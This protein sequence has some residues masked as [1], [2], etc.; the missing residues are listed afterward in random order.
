MKNK[1]FILTSLK[2]INSKKKS[3]LC[4][5]NY[6]FHSFIIKVENVINEEDRIEKIE[7]RLEG[8][9]SD[10]DNS[11][12]LLRYEKLE[13]SKK[14]EKLGVY[15]LDLDLLE[16]NF[17]IDDKNKNKFISVIP[18][19]LKCREFTENEN[20]FN[21]DISKKA[22]TVSKYI[23]GKLENIST[24]V[25][26]EKNFEESYSEI[27]NTYISSIDNS[28]AIVFTGEKINKNAL[29]DKN[30]KIYDFDLEKFSL[31]K[32]PNFLPED[33]KNIYT[34]FYNNSKNL[35]I[36]FILSLFL[37]VIGIFL[38]YKINSLENIFVN[39]QI[40][41]SN[42]KDEITDVREKMAEIEKS[43]LYLEKEL[44]KNKNNNLK[45]NFLLNFL[46]KISEDIK[47]KSIERDKNSIINIV[48]MSYESEKVI[49][50]LNKIEQSEFFELV[51]Y[52]YI[53]N[54]ENI[55]EFKAEIKYVYE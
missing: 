48:G 6:F 31:D 23:L 34:Y 4:L 3:I 14:D 19:F 51:N 9:F 15:L 11:K 20:Y 49:E 30:K 21:F 37:L 52:D 50:F 29:I 10:Y 27:I 38:N 18:S 47:I 22:I 55:F 53:I 54:T 7:D 28:Y 5:E 13:E 39:I 17:I 12:Y 35:L 41:N 42:I 1:K 25:I 44:E 16:E 8:I 26:E 43:K 32:S 36:L 45:L 40:K 24:Y 33:L 46:A 2:N